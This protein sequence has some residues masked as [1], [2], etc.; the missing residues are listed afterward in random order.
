MEYIMA[1]ASTIN[2]FLSYIYSSLTLFFKS[3]NLDGILAPFCK[4]NLL[5]SFLIFA[6]LTV[7]FVFFDK[8]QSLRNFEDPKNLI[9]TL[10]FLPIYVVLSNRNLNLSSF[11]LGTITVHPFLLIII[12]KL[13]GPVFTGAFGAAEYLLFY[14]KN[15]NDP[16]MFSLFFIYAIGGFLHGWIIYDYK[17]SFWRCILA[18]LVTVVLCNVILIPLVRAGTYTHAAPLSEFI[19]QTITT[20]I[21]QI[22]IQAILGYLSLRL[23]KLLR[24]RF[25][26]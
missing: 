19:P 23:I 6:A 22:P 24:R 7:Y 11:G 21:L 17:T 20:N 10:C 13:Y 12:A 4:Y 5:I 14:V 18:R 26:F 1:F 9:I 16:L 25:E 15:P 2:S 8:K 3:I